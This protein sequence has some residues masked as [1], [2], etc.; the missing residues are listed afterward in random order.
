[1]TSFLGKTRHWVATDR[2]G[3]RF[4]L[5]FTTNF[6]KMKKLNIIP[7]KWLCYAFLTSL[8]YFSSC[9]TDDEVE[10]YP[11]E[12]NSEILDGYSEND[13]DLSELVEFIDLESMTVNESSINEY[14][15]RK[16]NMDFSSS[17]DDLRENHKDWI[18]DHSPLFQ[19][20]N[21]KSSSSPQAKIIDEPSNPP[22][23]SNPPKPP[24]QTT[25]SF[26][27]Q[28]DAN[29]DKLKW[30]AAALEHW[31]RL[32]NIIPEDG[33]IIGGNG[34]WA[35]DEKLIKDKIHKIRFD[36][37]VKDKRL[38]KNE[39]DALYQAYVRFEYNISSVRKVVQSNYGNEDSGGV[40][41]RGRFTKIW[42]RVRSVLIST[43]VGA[44]A[45]FL[46]CICPGGAIV[47]AVAGFVGS[48]LDMAINK[49]CH[50][51]TKC[52]EGWMQNC[53][54]GACMPRGQESPAGVYGHNP[55]AGNEVEGFSSVKL[56][57]NESCRGCGVT[58]GHTIVLD[59]IDAFPFI[60][61]QS[62]PIPFSLKGMIDMAK[63]PVT[64]DWKFMGKNELG[65]PR[66]YQWFWQQYTD[67]HGALS[68]RNK[69][70]IRNGGSP[71]VDEQWIAKMPGESKAVMKDIIHH[72]H[73]N[74]GR[75]AIPRS[76]SLHNKAPWMKDLHPEVANS[77]V[78]TKRPKGMA[79]HGKTI[80]GRLSIFAD[81]YDLITSATDEDPLATYN[82]IYSD[83][84]YSITEPDTRFKEGRLY[85][86]QFNDTFIYVD[87][88][89]PEKG[90]FYT[91]YESYGYDGYKK[92]YIGVGKVAGPFYIQFTK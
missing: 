67:P 21:L 35:H 13:L 83:N 81:I 19:S 73:V 59:N 68:P 75:Y 87:N 45:G 14:F 31:D 57:P 65:W 43:A 10:V 25:Q 20:T 46:T 3:D 78:F 7:A 72:H 42:R 2:T 62:G 4:I 15:Q 52:A 6:L 23:P 71:T 77:T 58:T 1:M 89:S 92:Q 55:L 28:F 18:F 11:E 27:F 61:T 12:D 30:S 90:M 37:L 88:L 86:R 39:A 32:Y 40:A 74:R 54:T 79:S 24:S 47:G 44:G 76:A 36:I 70:I 49:R 16:Y 91:I 84:G 33:N 26:Y 53:N 34:D 60:T 51:A 9:Q 48:F 50:Y 5:P 85:W 38:S 82:I 8:F 41:A 80:I 66:N 56:V 29:L 63:A 17:Y 64:G 22:N 69:A